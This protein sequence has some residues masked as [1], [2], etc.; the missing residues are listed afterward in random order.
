MN[1]GGGAGRGGFS[2]GRGPFGQQRGGEEAQYIVPSN[3][4]GVIIGRGMLNK[5]FVKGIDNK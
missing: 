3:K 1:R 2:G 4:C 5:Y